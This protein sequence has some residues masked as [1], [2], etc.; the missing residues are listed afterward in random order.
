VQDVSVSFATDAGA[1]EV[2]DRVSFGI[3][4]GR[5][6]A[7]VGES[8]CGKSVTASS[9]MRLLPQ[10]HGTVTGGRIL[11]EGSDLLQLPLRE[12]YRIRG[13]RIS[14]I[15]Q[16]PMTALNPVQTAGRQIG[17]TLELH[18]EEIARNARAAE[19]LRILKEVGMPSPESR[20]AS[21]PFQLSGG[22]RQRVMIAMALAGRP[23][24]LIADEPTTALDVTVQ[25]QILRLIADLQKSSAMSVLYITHDMG[26]V[27]EISD[28][29]TVMY[30][31]QVVEAGP[32]S[33]IFAHPLHP[34]TRGLIRSMPQLA[35][36]PKSPLPSIPG[37][38]PSPRAYPSTCRFA[39][40]CPL[41]DDFCRTHAPVL[42]GIEGRRP[43]LNESPSSPPG[44]R[45][46]RC[47]KPGQT[48]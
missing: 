17:E 25:A 30:A 37:T 24:L 5:T 38:V 35:S 46:V 6:M 27:A 48:Q 3:L 20:M 7:L 10:P 40:R 42:E 15:F 33:A 4:P 12:M 23:R 29:V 28:E 14:M 45:L 36:A 2:V 26:V 16:E 1:M 21:Y 19:T 18:R 34:Y 31:G 9:I 8:G 44:G 43:T 32:V 13:S 39:D 11:F 47:F 41:A 22:M